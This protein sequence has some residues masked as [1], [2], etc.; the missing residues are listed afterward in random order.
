MCITDKKPNQFKCLLVLKTLKCSNTPRGSF[1]IQGSGKI[2]RPW[3]FFL[4]IS[5][6]SFPCAGAFTTFSSIC[7]VKA[8]LTS[9]SIHP[10]GKLYERWILV[11]GIPSKDTFTLIGLSYITWFLD[12]S[13]WLAECSNM[14]DLGLMYILHSKAKYWSSS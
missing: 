11:A 6:Y 4:Y 7:H 8:I 5:Q 12:H 10:V 3:L 14:I 1:L 9:F 13:P 2:T